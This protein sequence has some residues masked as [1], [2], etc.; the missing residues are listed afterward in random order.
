[1]RIRR[2]LSLATPEPYKFPNCGMIRICVRRRS[3]R[4]ILL[5]W[6]MAGSRLVVLILVVAMEIARQLTW[7]DR[8]VELF[9]D[10]TRV[11]VEVNLVLQDRSGHVI[12]IEV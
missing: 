3:F 5:V 2:R 4:T 11:Q 8:T 7:T 10:R 12:G 9:C 6:V 1:M